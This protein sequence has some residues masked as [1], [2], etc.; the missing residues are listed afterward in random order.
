MRSIYQGLE[1]QAGDIVRTVL[2]RADETTPP[3]SDELAMAWMERDVLLAHLVQWMKETPLII[4]PVGA[5]AAFEHG[6]RRVLVEESSLSIFRAFGYAR[7]S[8]VLG[9][10]S[11]SIPAGRTR[12]GLPIGVQIIGGPFAE[13]MI[14]AAATLIEERLGGW[15]EPLIL[16]H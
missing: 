7:F 2:A 12:E 4:A 3:S 13:R 11:V 16:N 8:N 15:V 14:L 10:P 6:A 9:L 1:T 5:A